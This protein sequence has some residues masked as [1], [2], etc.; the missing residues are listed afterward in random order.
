LGARQS[1]HLIPIHSDP[2]RFSLGALKFNIGLGLVP[3]FC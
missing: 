2:N 3:R 1:C